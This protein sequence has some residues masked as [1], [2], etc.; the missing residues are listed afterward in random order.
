[1]RCT[2]KSRWAPAFY[3]AY[4][5][6]LTDYLEEINYGGTG[7]GVPPAPNN[8]GVGVGR[9]TGAQLPAVIPGVGAVPGTAVTTSLPG[10]TRKERLGELKEL[11]DEELIITQ[12][13]FDVRRREILAEV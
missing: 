4:Y 11:L 13:E 5:K 7:E 8:G 6:V 2:Q 1:M 3:D 10:R 12:E 9:Q